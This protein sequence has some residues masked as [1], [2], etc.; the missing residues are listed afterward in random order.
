M[1]FHQLNIFVAVVRQKSFSRAAELVFLSQPTVSNHVKALEGMVGT[2]LI[3]R[4]QK[5]LQLTRAGK[6]LYQYAQQLVDLKEEALAA[7]QDEQHVLR[8]PLK[9]A[10]SSVP[11]AYILPALL[12]GF[13]DLHPAVTFTLMLRDT[14]RVYEAIMDYSYS[15][16]FVGEPSPQPQLEQIKL[17]SDELVLISPWDAGLPFKNT[18]D[19]ENQANL[20]IVDLKQASNQQELL[21]LPFISRE[22]GS[23]TRIV[24]ERALQNLYGKNAVMNIVALLESQEALKETVK[25]GLG[26]AVISLLAVK[27]ELAA[28]ELMGYR[29]P[30]LKMTRD[31]YLIH[32]KN[33]VSAPLDKAFLNYCLQE[34]S[35]V[36]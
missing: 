11:G 6:I 27:K 17:A 19:S 3:D 12:K 23:A 2:P 9:V 24:F 22:P 18:K 34:C 5:E 29:L 1:D 33:Q 26:V 8:G 10:A 32:R 28:G 13:K 25:T 31:Y 21:A 15:L 14:Q 30:A 7:L 16:G 36:D 35:P 4:S 20:K